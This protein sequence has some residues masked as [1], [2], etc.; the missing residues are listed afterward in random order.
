M[1]DQP[2]QLLP[3]L[4]ADE[5]AALREDIAVNGIRVPVDVDEAGQLLDG[6]HRAAIAAELGIPCPTRVVVGLTEDEKRHHALAVN[7]QRRTLTREQRRALVAAEL[8]HDPSRSDR[9]IG[10]ICG[11]DHKTVAATRRGGWGIPHP[12][13]PAVTREEAERRTEEIRAGLAM[14]D[15]R[16]MAAL[17][18]GAAPAEIVLAL[19]P[20]A[21]FLSGVADEHLAAEAR[22][23]W[24]NTVTRPRVDAAYAWPDGGLY[25]RLALESLTWREWCADYDPALAEAAEAMLREEFG[26]L[27]T[28]DGGP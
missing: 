2:Y 12:D 18:N 7:L 13:R 27:A 23:A 3:P 15:F 5:Y 26:K 11:V 8:E 19:Q 10:R 1:S 21:D 20:P 9:A 25:R 22:E 4:G 6:H 28:V 24:W 16:C 17:L 14:F